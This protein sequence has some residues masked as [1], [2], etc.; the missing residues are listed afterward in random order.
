MACVAHTPYRFRHIT[1]LSGPTC[2]WCWVF[3]D[4]NSRMPL[5]YVS[6]GARASPN[7]KASFAAQNSSP[8]HRWHIN[9]SR[10]HLH[11][12][13]SPSRAQGKAASNQLVPNQQ[14]LVPDVSLLTLLSNQLS[15]ELMMQHSRRL[16]S[17]FNTLSSW[18]DMQRRKKVS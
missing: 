16:H 14:H 3:K 11:G 17:V 7:V 9:K 13:L 18:Q 10:T 2:T 8:I 4:E 15:H 5:P 12:D 6:L 1:Y